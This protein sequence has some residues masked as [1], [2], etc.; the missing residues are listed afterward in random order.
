[1]AS[2]AGRGRIGTRKL[3]PA[4]LLTLSLVALLALPS[5]AVA[6]SSI[7]EFSTGLSPNSHPSNITIGPDGNLWSTEPGGAI[8]KITPSG[9]ITEYS[10]GLN[11]E[12]QPF[13]IVAGPDG[14]LWF[15]DDP[16]EGGT[17]AIGRITP[18]GT[19]TEFSSGVNQ[20]SEPISLSE[21]Q[22]ITVGPD[23]N[24]WFSDAPFFFEGQN[25]AIGRITPSG[26]ITEFELP[27][28]SV[29][30][31]LVVG[32]DGNLWFADPSRGPFNAAIGRITT[33]GTITEFSAS[34][35]GAPRSIVVGPDKNLWFTASNAIGRITTAGVITPFSAGLPAES[36][37]GRIV[38]GPDGNLW[39]TDSGPAFAEEKSIGRITT[40]GTITEFPTTDPERRPPADLIAGPDNNLWFTYDENPG[41]SRITPS[42][43]VTNFADGLTAGSEPAEITVGP[44]GSN[45]WFADPASG[46]ERGAIGRISPVGPA[47]VGPSPMLSI[48]VEGNGSVS[49]APA[50]ISCG[51]V[52]A[53]EFSSGATVTLTATPEPG[54]TFKGWNEAES[55]PDPT[56]CNWLPWAEGRHCTGTAPCELT[57]GGDTNVSAVFTTTGGGSEGSGSPPSGSQPPSSPQPQKA[58]KKQLKCRKGFKKRKVH[59]K[60]RCVKAKRKHHRS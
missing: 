39:F 57:I 38:V 9:T 47:G 19:I 13:D 6:A 46:E 60:A 2:K 1:M 40:S 24:L 54:S 23:G 44:G 20:D 52:C 18:S 58:R 34:A 43:V 51:A 56:T 59:G 37:L 15:T 22:G 50:G 11:P 41:I 48:S 4:V 55:C 42:G 28:V 36:N 27:A 32:P 7:T 17:P 31:G 3:K 21:P 45:L 29:P 16:F 35:T 33:S 8:V 49:S 53:S 14:N 5:S 25:S 30:E 26:T 12:S 10:T